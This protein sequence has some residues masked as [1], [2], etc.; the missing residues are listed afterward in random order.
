MSDS[1]QFFASVCIARSRHRHAAHEIRVPYV[2]QI[3]PLLVYGIGVAAD[4]VDTYS[5]L[6]VAATWP[7]NGGFRAV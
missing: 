6:Q 1:K 2:E 7:S 5:H 3:T 4:I